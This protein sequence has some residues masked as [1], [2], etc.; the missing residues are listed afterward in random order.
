MFYL[1]RKHYIHDPILVTN[2]VGIAVEG[3]G[4]KSAEL[5]L[6][7]GNLTPEQ[8][9][10]FANDLDS[11]P[12]RTTLFSELE[13]NFTYMTLQMLQIGDTD[14]LMSYNS[15]VPVPITDLT[16]FFL[17][18][19]GDRNTSRGIPGYITH[20]PFDRNIAGKRIAEF[21]SA[22]AS[23]NTAWNVNST[24]MKQHYEHLDRIIREKERQ[25][26]SSLRLLRVPLIRT[27]S[28]LLADY[29]ICLLTAAFVT[30]ERALDRTNTQFEL[31]RIAIALER[32][33]SANG[34]YPDNLD[35]LVPQFLEEV[36]L[37]PFTGRKTFVYKPHPDDETAFLIHSADWDAEDGFTRELFI[38][39]G[40][41]KDKKSVNTRQ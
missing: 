21:Q 13:Y 27:R 17:W 10:R 12:R 19:Y 9:E 39:L 6:Q 16:T 3:M 22:V 11:L 5:V 24:L 1:S 2:L 41:R 14:I 36:P 37:E 28:Q 31:L 15:P 34:E 25:L 23:G 20:L 18:L 29:M 32:Y 40:K 26:D 4:R 35:A 30:A 33:K 7:H 8:L 38:R